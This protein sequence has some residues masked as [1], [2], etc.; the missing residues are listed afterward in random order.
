MPRRDDGLRVNDILEAIGRI[1]AIPGD[2]HLKPSL[3]VTPACRANVGY[4]LLRAVYPPIR[5]VR[6]RGNIDSGVL[7]R[8]IVH[9]ALAGAPPTVIENAEIGAL[10]AVRS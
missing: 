9:A 2:S 7:A 10:G 4:P 3:S 8:A 5:L 6:T 1:R